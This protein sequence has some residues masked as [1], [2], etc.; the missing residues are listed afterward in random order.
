MHF[1][2]SDIAR[3]IAARDRHVRRH[4]LSQSP[5]ERLAALRDLLDLENLPDAAESH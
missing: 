2:D 5:A 1:D 4:A 3:E